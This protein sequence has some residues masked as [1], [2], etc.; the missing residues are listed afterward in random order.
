MLSL[1][2][3]AK[4]AHRVTVTPLDFE[5]DGAPTVQTYHGL[6]I[7]VDDAIIGRIVSWNPQVYQR[8]VNHVYELNHKTAGRPVDA[9]PGPSRGYTISAT[10]NEMWDDELEVAMGDTLYDD[11]ADQVRPQVIDEFLFKGEAL[12]RRWR[13]TGGWFTDRNVE[14]FSADGD[15]I[16]RISANF[17]YV[18]RSRLK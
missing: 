13:Y 5:A 1:S 2:P 10:R 14:G 4:N 15:F 12:Y 3:H 8:D 6:S 11:L 9:V 16:V 18:S 17:T 7:A